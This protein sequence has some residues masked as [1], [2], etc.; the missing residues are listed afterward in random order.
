MRLLRGLGWTLLGLILLVL[1]VT[2]VL[3][4]NIVDY[5]TML[6]RHAQRVARV[7]GEH[8][9]GAT[10]GQ[11]AAMQ[12]HAVSNCMPVIAANR[13]GE[14]SMPG[15]AAAQRFYGKPAARLSARESA[16][17][18]AVLPS[19]LARYFA[20]L[21]P[22]QLFELP[23]ALG[24]FHLEMVSLAQRQRDILDNILDPV[25]TLDAA[26]RVEELNRAALALARAGPLSPAATMPPIVAPLPKCGGSKAK[27]WPFSAKAASTSSKGVP[28][29]T[30]MTSSLGS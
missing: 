30:V 8:Q 28:Q 24:P 18:A 19:Q 12:G 7:L 10:E 22:L 16:L 14:E 23:F 6:R 29:R 13:I 26:G 5:G 11:H 17:L 25:L 2:A 1:I 4:G 9:E 3:L 27:L 15:T 20:S 21:L